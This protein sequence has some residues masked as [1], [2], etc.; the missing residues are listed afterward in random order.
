[1]TE[2][3]NDESASEF[4]ESIRTNES[5]AVESSSP[6]D[7]SDA[8][9]ELRDSNPC[10]EDDEAEPS[11]DSSDQTS[12]E[13]A[14][15]NLAN[16]QKDASKKPAKVALP[17][18]AKKVGIGV[19]IIVVASIL[20]VSLYHDW[21][22]ATCTEPQT[23]KICGK[24]QGD[25]LGHD[26]EDA[27]CTKPKTCKRCGSTDGAALGHKVPDDA[28]VV[29]VRPTCTSEGSEHGNCKRCGEQ[30]T[31]SIPKAAHT[32]GEPQV[33]KE[34]T[35]DSS[36]NAVAGEK[37]VYCTVCGAVIRT[38]KYTLSPEEI[39][40]QFKNSCESPSYED[41]ARNPDDWKGKKAAFKGKV[42]QVM[43][44]GNSYT[45]RVNVTEGRYGI[46]DDTILVSYKAASGSARI[47]E[48]DIMSFY[49]TMNGMYS[50]Q[51]VMGATITVPLLIASYAD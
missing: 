27:S 42:I 32:E 37:T 28:W 20:Y 36:G 19:V 14:A 11:P 24:T 43:Q 23:C 10:G 35:V 12:D 8:S 33:T 30:Q 25:P 1:M 5:P 26:Y 22:P 4:D 15:P 46:W 16:D 38:E 34:A 29:D 6:G 17:G 50:Y 2:D 48:D 3:R 41:V 18:W 21:A 7:K 45:L 51:S 39:E 13:S 9:E 47:L 40:D 44:D 31:K 49:G